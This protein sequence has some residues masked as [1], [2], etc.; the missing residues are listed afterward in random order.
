MNSE[1]WYEKRSRRPK[2]F[3]IVYCVITVTPEGCSSDSHVMIYLILVSTL[4][5]AWLGRF[6][7]FLS[8]LLFYYIYRRR[9][10]S[11]PWSLTFHLPVTV[12][13]TWHQETKKPNFPPKRRRQDETI[14]KILPIR[15]RDHRAF[16]ASQGFT[17]LCSKGK[18]GGFAQN[19]K[20]RRRR[21]QGGK[22]CNVHTHLGNQSCGIPTRCH[23]VFW[24]VGG[25]T[26]YNLS[27]LQQC[28]AVLFDTMLFLFYRLVVRQEDR[29]NSHVG[30]GEWSWAFREWLHQKK[31]K[32][33]V[34]YYLLFAKVLFILIIRSLNLLLNSFL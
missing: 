28:L 30:W 34:D 11:I 27:I 22:R 32:R 10:P 8:L 18:G 1:F 14:G 31:T 15:P 7:D 25:E 16:T 24:C 13:A 33:C 4:H 9:A 17:S 23:T 6:D 19:K 12:R 3:L 20:P 2:R 29:L 5:L 21:G 26:N